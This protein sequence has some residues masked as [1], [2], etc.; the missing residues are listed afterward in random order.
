MIRL[1][2]ADDHA[3]VRAA[4]VQMLRSRPEFSVEA[5]A[6]NAA[7]VLAQVAQHEFDLLL[8]DMS[9]PGAGGLG[10]L[11]R[12]QREHP[13]LP[14]VILSMHN[15]GQVV[16]RALKAGACGYVAKDSNIT[17]LFD[18]ITAVAGGGKFVDPS[19][20]HGLVFAEG[21]SQAPLHETLS[22]RERQV[23]AML[24]SGQRLSEIADR[25]HVS[26]KTISTHKMRLMQKLKVS[27]NADLVDYA[28]RHGLRSPLSAVVDHVE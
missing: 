11:E 16:A 18:A 10:L 2:V 13:G 27:N 12:L 8:L 28:I 24:V 15:D 17:T 25:L 14:V 23:L 4:L 22:E 26:A 6:A 19:L 20:V 21:A 1:L 3:M 5:E 9:M 7:D